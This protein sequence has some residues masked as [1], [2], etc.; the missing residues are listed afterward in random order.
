MGK[1]RVL[2][3]TKTLEEDMI[4][5]SNQSMLYEMLPCDWIT[6]DKTIPGGGRPA[7]SGYLVTTPHT[8]DPLVGGGGD[9]L[10]T[11]EQDGRA[12]S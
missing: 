9:H 2:K 6:D 4:L 12:P 11:G 7:G 5:T 3:R 1:K 8:R 10:Q